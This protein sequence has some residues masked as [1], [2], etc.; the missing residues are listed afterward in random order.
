MG[1]NKDLNI[2]QI[3]LI[4]IFLL[5]GI[6]GIGLFATGKAGNS[7]SK[8]DA[9]I[10][11]VLPK[12]NIDAALDSFRIRGQDPNF[13]YEEFE[14]DNF[15][16]ILLKAIA[17]GT[18]PD[19]IIFS[20]DMYYSQFNRLLTVPNDTITAEGYVNTY[21]DIANLFRIS[22]GVK[23]F[24]LLIDPLVMYYN[25]DILKSDG[26]ITA[27]KDWSENGRKTR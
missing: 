6:I 23:A 10:W 3:A 19:A 24:P 26:I 21:L 1:T 27:P 5:L 15:E 17:E 16:Q 22:G 9:V 7:A 11:G 14:R 8:Y 13:T 4:V 25:I 20:D 18:G 2:F 12:A